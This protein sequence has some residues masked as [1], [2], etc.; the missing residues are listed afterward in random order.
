M[1]GTQIIKWELDTTQHG[2]I[3]GRLVTVGN[4][5]EV[6]TEKESSKKLKLFG[7]CYLNQT[8]LQTFSFSSHPKKERE[9]EKKMLR[10]ICKLRNR[11]TISWLQLIKFEKSASAYFIKFV[12]N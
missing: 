2:H 8:I 4:I 6:A 12:R 1:N 7:S 5:S 3:I 10:F 11:L 9:R